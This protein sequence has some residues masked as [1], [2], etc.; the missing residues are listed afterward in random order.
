[1]HRTPKTPR[2]HFVGIHFEC[3]NVYT[4][5]YRRE[6]QR[7]YIGRCPN[8]LRTVRLRVGPDGSSARMF[9]AR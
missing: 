8:C 6:D 4:R 2:R 3:C 7:E 9:R 1:M 5:V